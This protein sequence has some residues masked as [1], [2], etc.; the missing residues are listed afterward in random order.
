MHAAAQWAG[1]APRSACMNGGDFSMSNNFTIGDAILVA[2]V[3]AENED[4]PWEKEEQVP[5]S[6]G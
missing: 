4:W 6:P 1:D 3:W 5:P 2:S